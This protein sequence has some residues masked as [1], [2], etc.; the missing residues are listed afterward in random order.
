LMGNVQVVDVKVPKIKL[1]AIAE[2]KILLYDDYPPEGFSDNLYP[3]IPMFSYYLPNFNDW[4]LKV[5]GVIRS[6][7]PAQKEYNK[8][9]SIMMEIAMSQPYGWKYEVGA[10]ENP[11][12]LDKSGARQKVEVRPGKM[13]ER[14]EGG[15]I[16]DQ[17]ASLHQMHHDDLTEIGPNPDLL[18]MVG[19]GGSAMDVSGITLKLRKDQG[20]MTLQNPFD[21]AALAHKAVGRYLVEMY[22]RWPKE[23]IQRIIGRQVPQDWDKRKM[24]SRFDCTI[25]EQSSSPTYQMATLATMMSMNEH[26]TV[27]PPM[28][29]REYFNI[30]QK[31]KDSWAAE[32]QKTVQMQL[33]QRQEDM[34]MQV[35]Q[36]GV[37]SKAD[38]DKVMA[39][40]TGDKEITSMKIESEEKIAM[41]KLMNDLAKS[42]IDENLVNKQMKLK[43]REYK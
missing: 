22:N 41:D 31:L 30:P 11:A 9:R 32:E 35:M 7:R 34:K 23:K 37:K 27:V 5:F 8:M 12:E 4:A 1:I 25:D 43:D 15:A 42:K 13:L 2:D 29:M 40:I 26:G 21:G 24:S 20:M 36:M 14:L 6:M 18:G 3:F 33:Q 38:M 28:V 17:L 19:A 10:V 39:Q 16:S